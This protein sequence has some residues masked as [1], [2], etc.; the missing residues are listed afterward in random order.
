MEKNQLLDRTSLMNSFTEDEK[1]LLFFYF[2]QKYSDQTI[3]R[4]LS[5][6]GY[7][8]SKALLLISELRKDYEVYVLKKKAQNDMIFGSLWFVGGIV[9][10][11]ANIGFFFWGAILFGM[12]QFFKGLTNYKNI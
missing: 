2:K 7:D 4:K 9:G 10:T 3:T 6:K 1:N 8:E 11:L 5:K 12:I